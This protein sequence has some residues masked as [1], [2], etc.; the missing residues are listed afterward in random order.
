MRRGFVA[1]FALT[2]VGAGLTG[3]GLFRF[4]QREPWRVQAEE[5]CLAQHL[6]QPSAYMAR[7]AKVDGPGACGMD[8]PFKVAAFSAGS[9]GVTKTVTLACPIIPRIELWLEEVVKPAAV[10]YYGVPVVDLRAGSYSCR[11]RNNLSGAKLSEHG[12]GN[13]LDVMAFVLADGRQVSVVKGWRG[14]PTDQDFLR[15]VFLGACQHF[16]TVLAPGSDSFHYDHLHIDLARHDPRGERRIC[17]PILKFMPRLPAPEANRRPAV[18]SATA[19]LP[20]I[21]MEQDFASDDAPVEEA[22][23]PPVAARA[24]IPAP[25]P[26][27]EPRYQAPPPIP[28]SGVAAVPLPPTALPPRG[29]VYGRATPDLTNGHGLY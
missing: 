22:P 20:S 15:E 25:R 2:L 4:E 24:P 11:P 7:S 3:C 17:K 9:V 8:Y 21:D 28:P 12:F 19:D 13:A 6:V 18:R 14:D 26:T 1:F 27:F 16:T 5:A 10:M 29:P 23:P